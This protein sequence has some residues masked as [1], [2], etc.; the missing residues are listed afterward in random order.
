MLSSEKFQALL[1]EVI[2]YFQENKVLFHVIGLKCPKCGS[3]NT[4]RSGERYETTNVTPQIQRQMS[5]VVQEQWS[6]E[7]HGQG[8]DGAQGTRS[9]VV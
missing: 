2:L 8:S 7:A 5:D 9:D 1:K 4:C 3:Y 6:E